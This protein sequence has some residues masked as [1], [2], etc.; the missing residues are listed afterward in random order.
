MDGG[1]I[2]D[3]T[4]KIRVWKCQIGIP[5]IKTY[6]ILA[7]LN[8]KLTLCQYFGSI[9]NEDNNNNFLHC[10]GLHIFWSITTLSKFGPELTV[11]SPGS[12]P[13]HFL[14]LVQKINDRMLTR[15]VT[16]ISRVEHERPVAPTPPCLERLH[17]AVELPSCLPITGTDI[18]ERCYPLTPWDGWGPFLVGIVAN[19][20]L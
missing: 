1:S 8:I 4:M 17:S 3:G 16:H 18:S 11:N 10:H 12:S 2:K 14:S 15:V 20:L 9:S 19:T 5:N 13:T 6:R 7:R